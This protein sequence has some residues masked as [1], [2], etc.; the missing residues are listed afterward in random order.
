MM[1]VYFYVNCFD[2]FDITTGYVGFRREKN[3]YLFPL[4]LNQCSVAAVKCVSTF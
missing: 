2:I 4:Q 1:F 3:V